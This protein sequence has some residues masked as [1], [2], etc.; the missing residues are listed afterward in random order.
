MSGRGIATEPLVRCQVTLTAEQ[1]AVMRRHGVAPLQLEQ[2]MQ[3]LIDTEVARLGGGRD[4]EH[5][6]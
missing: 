1:T 2:H 4:P 5:R 3:Q 6:A